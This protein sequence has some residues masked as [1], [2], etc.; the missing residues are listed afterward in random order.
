MKLFSS[1]SRRP[2]FAVRLALGAVVA[3]LAACSGNDYSSYRNDDMYESVGGFSYGVSVY[4]SWGYY[5]NPYY[6]GGYYGGGG[7]V[8]IAPPRPSHPIARPR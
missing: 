6:G 5:G 4:D 2:R 3:L 7:A 8:I 1:F